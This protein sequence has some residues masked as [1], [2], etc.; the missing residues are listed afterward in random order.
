ARGA[1]RI[2]ASHAGR[3]RD[4]RDR[5]RVSRPYHDDGAATRA[6]ETEDSRRGHSIYG[7]RHERYASAAGRGADGD[8][9]GLQ[10]RLRGDSR[11]GGSLVGADLCAEAIGLGRLVR[12]LMAPRPPAEATALLALMLLHDSRRDARLDEAGDLILLEEQDR[13]RWNQEQIAE[14]APLVEEALRG[15]V[16]SFALVG[17]VA[18]ADCSAGGARRSGGAPQRLPFRDLPDLRSPPRAA[19]CR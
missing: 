17:G 2:D 14:A 16:G 8:L 5:A 13:G 15:G 9:S 6:R 18:G 19:S 1:G 3:P 10:R 12:M 11:G 7:P 4:G